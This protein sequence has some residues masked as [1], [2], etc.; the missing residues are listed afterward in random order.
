MASSADIHENEMG[1][2]S[3]PAQLRCLDSAGNSGVVEP[4]TLLKDLSYIFKSGGLSGGNPTKWIGLGRFLGDPYRPIRI[5]MISGIYNASSGRKE[6]ELVLTKNVDVYCYGTGKGVIGYVIN[7]NNLDIYLKV[8]QT[9]SYNGWVYGAFINTI[10]DTQV[11]P[12][13][14]VYVP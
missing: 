3:N 7:G 6:I 11:E 4:G 12:S 5:D 8:V 10:G 13:G 2:I 1:V 9:E 14:I